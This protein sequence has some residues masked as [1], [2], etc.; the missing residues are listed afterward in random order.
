M[1]QDAHT[2]LVYDRHS[3]LQESFYILHVARHTQKLRHLH[4]L[5]CS[6]MCVHTHSCTCACTHIH[7]TL[8]SHTLS[9]YHSHLGTN[10]IQKAQ[11]D[12]PKVI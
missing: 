11:T 3:T 10:I 8:H 4:A 7:I 5:M 1:A 9:S 6:S 12:V 2:A